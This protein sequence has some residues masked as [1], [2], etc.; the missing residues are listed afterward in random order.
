VI[1][2]IRAFLN[3][4]IET[5]EQ[6]RRLWLI[7]VVVVIGAAIIL[8]LFFDNNDP[9]PKPQPVGERRSAPA[10][11]AAPEPV[12]SDPVPLPAELPSNPPVVPRSDRAA[13]TRAARTFARDYLAFQRGRRPADDIRATTESLRARLAALPRGRGTPASTENPVRLLGLSTRVVDRATIVVTAKLSR[14]GATFPLRA[15]VKHTDDRWLVS[16]VALDE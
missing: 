5:D 6:R 11:S 14:L 3:T 7:A 16:A 13:A 8:K 10:Q 15:T 9:G 4:P 12:A 2:R 1:S